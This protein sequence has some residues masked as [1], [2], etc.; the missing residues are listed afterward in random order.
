MTHELE[1][2]CSE[3]RKNLK[4]EEES[5]EAFENA[6][7]LRQHIEESSATRLANGLH[8]LIP[9]V[10]DVID[11]YALKVKGVQMIDMLVQRLE[12]QSFARQG[13]DNLIIFTLKKQFY[14]QDFELFK[15]LF[16][17]CA[18]A[19]VRFN[20]QPVN[21]TK[22]VTDLDEIVDI[23]LNLIEIGTDD[24]LRLL[25][26]QE[27]PK[28]LSIL[29]KAVY[30]HLNRLI[31]DFVYVV[32]PTFLTARPKQIAAFLLILNQIIGLTSEKF[33]ER[34]PLTVL[35]QLLYCLNELE[36]DPNSD[37]DKNDLTSVR[38][39]T[40]DC[41]RSIQR[42]NPSRFT[43]YLNELKQN[44]QLKPIHLLIGSDLDRLLE[45]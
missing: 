4:S 13:F 9:A 17:I 38:S 26:L 5:S 30:K 29:Q 43:S 39:G 12:H 42:L 2:I 19:L 14:H 20:F 41:L 22:P 11:N 3:I 7:R 18:N 27:L 21:T 34:K 37:V 15:C 8:L 33:D 40:L 24:Q 45:Q 25:C 44:E 6:D 32:D 10:L 28:L 23:V 35:V 36:A 31:D 1:N 16:T